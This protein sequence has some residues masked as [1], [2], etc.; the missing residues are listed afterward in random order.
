MR[1]VHPSPG[2]NLH[3]HNLH[4]HNLPAHAHTLTHWPHRLPPLLAR[5]AA[6]FLA[7]R[8]RAASCT[9][10]IKDVKRN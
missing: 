10:M 4:A 5:H 1:T 7:A 3:G 2:D 6:C 9:A 8:L